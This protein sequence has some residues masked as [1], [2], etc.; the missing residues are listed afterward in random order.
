MNK[1]S[2][3]K[4]LLEKSLIK[5]FTQT[6]TEEINK[7]LFKTTNH[8]HPVFHFRHGMARLSNQKTST[9][10]LKMELNHETKLVYNYRR[11]IYIQRITE[12]KILL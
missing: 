3:N 12:Q 2:Y 11:N 8:S 5:W 1:L 6:P 4:F 7:D 9:T 10:E